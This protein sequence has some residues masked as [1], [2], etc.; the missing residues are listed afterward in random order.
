[1]FLR[2]RELIQDLPDAEII[3]RTDGCDAHLGTLRAK[4]DAEE[5]AALEKAAYIT[6]EISA[7]AADFLQRSKS[8]VTEHEVAQLLEREAVARGAEGMGFETLAAGPARSWGIHP[9]PASTNGPFGVNG[10]SIL[11]F[12]VKVDGYTSDVTIT[13]ARGKLTDG[14][15]RMIDLVEQAYAVAL[16][17]A[18]PGVSPREPAVKADQL[19]SAVGQRMPHALGHG[20]GLDAHERPLLH[21][22]GSGT[23]SALEPGMVFTLEPGLYHPQEGGVRWEN[24]F[25]MTETG[26]RVLTGARIIRL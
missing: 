2:H 16:R 15:E 14:Q 25:L 19:F 12:G 10:L 18:R 8:G 4:K 9:F 26:P 13:V 6:D 22:Q 7:L 11:D 23:D 1:M 5:L 20:I 17:A 21:A 3:I 24:D